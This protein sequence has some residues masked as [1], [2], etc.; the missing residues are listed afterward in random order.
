MFP[1]WRI[2]IVETIHALHKILKTGG[3]MF[4]GQMPQMKFEKEYLNAKVEGQ[5]NYH[6]L[7]KCTPSHKF[8]EPEYFTKTFGS[9]FSTI[10]FFYERENKKVDQTV[11][12][13]IPYNFG[14]YFKK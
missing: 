12:Y 8:F 3:E 1:L 4:I 11:W 9:K 7:S 10:K 14:V 2:N 5:K 13:S 6:H